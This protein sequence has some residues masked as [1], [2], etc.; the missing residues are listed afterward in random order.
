VTVET[1]VDVVTADDEVVSGMLD[2]VVVDPPGGGGGG[3]VVLGV[4]VVAPGIVEVVVGA[5][6]AVVVEVGSLGVA[7]PL[8]K[9]E[10]P[11]DVQFLPAYVSPGPKLNG[12]MMSPHFVCLGIAG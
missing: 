9:M 1:S 7:H 4:V 3:V 2:D 8:S 10:M 12:G 6:V 5:E 11:S